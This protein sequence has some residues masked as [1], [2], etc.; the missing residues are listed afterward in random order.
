MSKKIEKTTKNA[1]NKLRAYMPAIKRLAIGAGLLILADSALAA[2]LE[3]SMDSSE[4]SVVAFVQFIEMCFFAG[5]FFFVGSGIWRMIKKK[6]NPQD[7]N[8]DIFK[9][10]GLG[11]ALSVVGLVLNQTTGSLTNAEDN[12]MTTEFGTRVE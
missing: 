11:A 1:G 6:D 10:I 9:A 3:E 2:K 7:T 5:G 4:A 12:T 8:G